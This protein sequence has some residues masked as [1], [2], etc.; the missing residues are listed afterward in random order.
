MLAGGQLAADSQ[1]YYTYIV[2]V[3]FQD[4]KHTLALKAMVTYKQVRN[5]FVSHRRTW[6]LT[7]EKETGDSSY[8]NL[9]K[10]TW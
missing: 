3:F 10:S 1:Y 6:H 5:W 7:R 2:C 8:R 4:E 9:K